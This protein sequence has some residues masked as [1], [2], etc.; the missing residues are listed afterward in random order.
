MMDFIRNCF[1]EPYSS[2]C[3]IGISIGLVIILWMIVEILFENL[4]G[5]EE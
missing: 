2:L 1:K 5:K 3:L 4:F